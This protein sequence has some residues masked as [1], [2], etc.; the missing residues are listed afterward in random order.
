MKTLILSLLL[1]T[2][3]FAQDSAL[4]VAAGE[5]YLVSG[6]DDLVKIGDYLY[7]Q[8]LKTN[9]D[10]QTVGLIRVTTEAANVEILA[11]DKERNPVEVEKLTNEYYQIRKAGTYWIDVTAIDFEKNIYRRQQK[12]LSISE[13][14]D[15]DPPGPIPDP[16]PD[17]TPAPIPEPGLHIL[18][19]SESSDASTL[20]RGQREILFSLEGRNFLNSIA[21]DKWRAFDQH[22]QFTDPNGVWAKALKRPRTSLP[23]VIISNGVTGFEGPMPNNLAEF[24][25]M[26]EI[27]K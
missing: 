6:A 26:V 22:V 8:N 3:V 11:S 14:P 4:T 5:A 25:G 12:K 2:S 23:W 15:V 27:Y 1:A 16:T 20:T 9:I 7:L 21:G 19:V 18:F 10:Y 17:P 24:K 13:N